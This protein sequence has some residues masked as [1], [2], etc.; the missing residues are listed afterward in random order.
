MGETIFVSKDLLRVMGGAETQQKSN[1]KLEKR[2]D[3]G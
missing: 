3:A 2:E 1:G